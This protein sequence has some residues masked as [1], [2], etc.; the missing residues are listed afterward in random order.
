MSDDGCQFGFFIY[1]ENQTAVDVKKA[2]WKGE[3]VNFVG[4]NNLYR[5][6][7]FAIG[8]MGNILRDT[9]HVFLEGRILNKLRPSLKPAPCLTPDRHLSGTRLNFNA[10]L[11]EIDCL[12]YGWY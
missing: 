12:S 11:I 9:I 10:H 6:R 8:F 1:A 5:D 2:A 7:N 3:G 4:I